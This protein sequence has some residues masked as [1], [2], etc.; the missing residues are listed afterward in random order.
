MNVNVNKININLGNA[1]KAGAAALIPAASIL[2]A[3]FEP[4][5]RVATSAIAGAL[6]LLILWT[7]L[8]GGTVTLPGLTLS[9]RRPPAE[10]SAQHPAAPA[11][12]PAPQ[13]VPPPPLPASTSTGGAG[14]AIGF[15][16]LL[17]AVVA[18]VWGLTSASHAATTPSPAPVSLC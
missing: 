4:R 13:P 15:I 1:G 17:A 8:R 11:A 5:A 2:L 6:A 7:L 3:I 12:P 10:L 16:V 18:V 9:G 14:A